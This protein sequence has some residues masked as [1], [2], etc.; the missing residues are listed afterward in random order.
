MSIETIERAELVHGIR[1]DIHKRYPDFEWPEPVLE[2]IFFGRFDKTLVEG[3][4][5]VMDKSAGTQWDVV[6]SKYELIPHE[7]VLN[8]LLCACPEYAGTPEVKLKKWADG[9]GFRAEVTFPNGELDAEIKVGDVVRARVC[10][11]SS[12][13]RS[14]LYGFECGGEQLVC[15]NGCVA[16][17]G[18]EGQKRKHLISSVE[19]A[20]IENIVTGFLDNWAVQTG[21]WKKWAEHLLE[22]A[23]VA[24]IVALLPFTDNEKKKLVELPLLNHDGAWI[25]SLEEKAT[26]WDINSAA[27]QM[28]RHEIASDK[29]SMALESQIAS[30]MHKVGDVE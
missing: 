9:A 24:T 5:L 12:Y 10:G 8:T 22:P 27:T 21:A 11:Y 6:S 23:E 14:L 13:N 26:L 3:K 19:P 20:Q 4:L 1:E 17:V 16:F 30:V 29:R 2:P 7:M 28:A 15:S 25:S 18:E